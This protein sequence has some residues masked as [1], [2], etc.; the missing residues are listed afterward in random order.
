MLMH[1]IFV[2]FFFFFEDKTLN[3]VAHDL[4]FVILDCVFAIRC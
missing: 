1:L 2:I 4:C 3:E